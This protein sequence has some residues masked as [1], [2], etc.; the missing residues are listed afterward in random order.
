VT[1]STK[2][3][4]MDVS[5]AAPFFPD[6]SADGY[7]V[8]VTRGLPAGANKKRLEGRRN[9]VCF[10]SNVSG[11]SKNVCVHCVCVCVNCGISV[12]NDLVVVSARNSRTDATG[13]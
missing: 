1:D 3:Q 12:A 13:L 4:S 2:N 8:Q 9:F 6:A 7:R 5:S 10:F 11:R